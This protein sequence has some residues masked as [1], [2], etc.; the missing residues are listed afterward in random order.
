MT[1]KKCVNG[2]LC[3]GKIRDYIDKD[4]NGKNIIIEYC[5]RCGGVHT[6]DPIILSKNSS[7]KSSL[8]GEVFPE[9]NHLQ[10]RLSL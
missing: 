10:Y 3:G 2:S 7:N 8:S 5:V 9:Q 1:C 4:S 6:L